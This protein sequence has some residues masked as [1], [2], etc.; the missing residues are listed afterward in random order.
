M[1]LEK[2]VHR[3][4]PYFYYFSV[5]VDADVRFVKYNNGSNDPR[6]ETLS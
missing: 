6:R 4:T 5:A 3:V 1:R 2:N